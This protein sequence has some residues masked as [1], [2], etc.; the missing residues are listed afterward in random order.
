MFYI[1][2]IISLV[3]PQCDANGDGDLNVNDIVSQIDCILNDCW[4]IEV[5]EDA[6][7]YDDYVYQT[8]WINDVH[9]MAEN[10][11]TTHYNNG[12]DIVNIEWDDCWTYNYEPACADYDESESNTAI[13]G[14]LYNQFA[15]DDDRNICPVGWH[16]PSIN[17]YY[18]LTDYLG[19]DVAGYQ[20][21]DN[22][23]W[24]GSNQSQFNG[25]PS[26]CRD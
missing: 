2:L 26:G 8:V 4:Y 9:W 7:N 3:Y 11:R 14:K 12:D 20:M 17:D 16:I 22:N 6:I 10:L 5:E 13:H 21:K 24:D 15:V 25:L 23:A 1:L 18:A 19:E